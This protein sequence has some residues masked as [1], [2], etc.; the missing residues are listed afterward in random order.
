[1]ASAVSLYP[2]GAAAVQQATPAP[3][4]GG[5]TSSTTG[6][7]EDQQSKGLS[8][9]ELYGKDV[10]YDPLDDMVDPAQAGG[11]AADAE[12]KLKARAEAATALGAD[13]ETEREVDAALGVQSADLVDELRRWRD[14]ADANRETRAKARAGASAGTRSWAVMERLDTS[15][16]YEQVPNMALTFRFEL[17]VFQKESILH[18]EKGESV[19]VAAHTSAGKTVVAAYAIALSIKHL[20][21]AIYT[22]PIKTLSNQKYR[23]FRETFKPENVGVITGDVSINP[24]ASCLI[25]TTEILRSML[26]KGADLIRDIEWVIFDEVHY[27]NDA[28]RGVVWEEVTRDCIPTCRP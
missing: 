15:D 13:W 18:I 25:V 19:F 14:R 5:V 26:Y 22:S 16:F 24:D 21:R 9:D 10:L 7:G 2:H 4:P 3:V 20:T 1:V 17:D 27:I 6:L 23:E 28:E 11:L 8:F 12:A